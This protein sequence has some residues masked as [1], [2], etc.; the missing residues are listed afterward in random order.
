MEPKENAVPSSGTATR[1]DTLQYTKIKALLARCR[2]G[3]QHDGID[4][5]LLVITHVLQ[6]ARDVLLERKPSLDQ[7]SVAQAQNTTDG[8]QEGTWGCAS[9]SRVICSATTMLLVL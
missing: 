4:H 6:Q 2:R 1:Q 9:A 7:R 3:H 5:V 8:K